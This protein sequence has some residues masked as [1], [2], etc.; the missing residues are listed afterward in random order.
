VTNFNAD[1]DGVATD[2]IIRIILG[3]VQE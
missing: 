1:A 2:E 3:E